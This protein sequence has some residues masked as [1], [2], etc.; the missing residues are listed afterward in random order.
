MVN[1]KNSTKSPI[2]SQGR[3]VLI[4]LEILNNE[5]DIFLT[6]QNKFIRTK[7]GKKIPLQQRTD[8]LLS[9][10]LCQ[11]VSRD[12]VMFKVWKLGRDGEAYLLNEIQNL[13]KLI[14]QL[15]DEWNRL[16]TEKQN[17][18]SYNNSPFVVFGGKTVKQK[19]EG[20][21]ELVKK[22]IIDME[23]YIVM[24]QN[25]LQKVKDKRIREEKIQSQEQIEVI[26]KLDRK[27][28]V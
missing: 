19:L 23:K 1:M 25:I 5:F 21:L 15:K 14:D 22:D 8:I 6:P 27:S 7:D 20:K 18:K 16:M 11:H 13:E 4:G 24:L 26:K 28:D 2:V 10:I 17:V 3:E 9:E 12:D